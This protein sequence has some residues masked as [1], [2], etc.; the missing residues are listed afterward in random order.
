L[1]ANLI[2]STPVKPPGHDPDS[3]HIAAIPEQHEAEQ[4][5]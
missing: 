3:A 4:S 1:F 5:G 2:L